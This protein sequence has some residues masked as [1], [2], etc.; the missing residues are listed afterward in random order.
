M[1]TDAFTKIQWL[2]PNV[3]RWVTDYFV[4][5]EDCSV[6]ISQSENDYDPEGYSFCVSKNMQQDLS[7]TLESSIS[8][9]LGKEVRIT[10]LRAKI[11]Q[12]SISGN[13]EIR[14]VNE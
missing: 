9:I 2:D 12:Q 6:M 5:D 7:G 4:D 8:Y 13:F 14:D 3:N 11:Y 1:N 10:I